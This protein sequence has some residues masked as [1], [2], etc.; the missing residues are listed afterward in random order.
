[1]EKTIHETPAI[2]GETC[3]LI[4]EAGRHFPKRPSRETIE[5][6]IRKGVRGAILETVKVGGNRFTSK[7]AIVR[8]LTAQVPVSNHDSGNQNGQQW[9]TGEELEMEKQ[10]VGLKR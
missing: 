2:L 5:R 9:A 7:E 4:A 1:M 10:D 6:W 3:L 8:F